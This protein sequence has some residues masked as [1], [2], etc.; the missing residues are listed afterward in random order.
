MTALGFA[1]SLCIAVAVDR[2]LCRRR[3]QADSLTNA[4][5]SWVLTRCEDLAYQLSEQQARYKELRLVAAASQAKYL[6]LERHFLS[7]EE[8]YER[9]CAELESDN[10]RLQSQIEAQQHTLRLQP[11][12]SFLD[13]LVLANKLLRQEKDLARMQETLGERER[14]LRSNA[15][16]TFR[17][18]VLVANLVWRQQKQI[19]LLKDEA[20]SL[21]RGRIRAVT[22]SAKQMVLDTRREGM[23]DELVNGLIKDIESGKRRERELK[24]KY[25]QEV[26]EHRL[27]QRARL[28]EQEISNEV[29]DRLVADLAQSRRSC[30]ELCK[31]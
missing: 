19:K 7:N 11:F 21:K 12:V 10:A 4:N 8:R 6:K 29:E 17:D 23:V 15:F 27:A 31:H 16:M 24:E 28:I 3:P 20:E 30:G 9:R 1:A 26:E 2:V 22:R 18:R 25:D 5:V 13:R 14:T